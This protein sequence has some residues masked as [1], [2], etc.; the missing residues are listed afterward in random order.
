[1]PFPVSYHG[2]VPAPEAADRPHLLGGLAIALRREGA[3]DIRVEGE[4]LEFRVKRFSQN[5]VSPI[6]MAESG[7]VRILVGPDGPVL[8][9]EV[10]V[11]RGVLFFTAV[12]LLG[13]GGGALLI[14]A[15][16]LFA[17]IFA[18]FVWIVVLGWQ[19]VTSA[20]GFARF[21][22]RLAAD[23][24]PAGHLTYVEADERFQS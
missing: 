22:R 24:R 18:A 9:Y 17:A 8:K 15:P 6:T 7:R 12:C 13:L 21:L 11:R 14:G 20:S 10:S 3:R 23:P 1:M 2:E 19:F 16:L 4:S 5:G